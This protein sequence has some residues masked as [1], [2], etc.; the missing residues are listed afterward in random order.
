[1]TNVNIVADVLYVLGGAGSA[2]GRKVGFVKSGAKA[3]QNDTWTI[4]N[5][6][7]VDACYANVDAS[8]VNEPNTIATNV[9]TLTSATATS[10]SGLIVF[11]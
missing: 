10:C 3:A 11:R 2:T 6:G 9:I 8:G 1:M 5:A 7:A 4:V